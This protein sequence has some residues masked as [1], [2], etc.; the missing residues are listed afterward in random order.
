[1][2]RSQALERFDPEYRERHIQV[3]AT[4]TNGSSTAT[5]VQPTGMCASTPPSPM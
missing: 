5:L 2:S 3:N 1:M 4:S